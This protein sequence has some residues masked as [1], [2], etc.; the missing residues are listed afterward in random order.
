MISHYMTESRGPVRYQVF[1]SSTFLDLK[2]QRQAAVQALL[3][4]GCIPLG[5]EIF[6]AANERQ[7][8]YIKRVIAECDY[9]VV[10][11]A[12][13]YGSLGSRGLSY[14]EMEYRYARDIGK[15]LIALLHE[16]HRHLP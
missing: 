15:P 5:M 3:E 7:W 4:L 8:N 11:S 12:G 16:K 9:Y 13:K 1:I 14:T 10:I 6:P 2:A